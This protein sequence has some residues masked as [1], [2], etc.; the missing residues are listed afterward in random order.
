MNHTGHVHH[1][2][3]PHEHHHQMVT[4]TS[5]PAALHDSHH[6]H[7]SHDHAG[8]VMKMWFHGGC[9]EVILFDWWRTESCVGKIIKN[10]YL[11]KF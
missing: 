8:H 5:A 11:F 1:P 6:Q 4:T 3:D 9:N 10:K 7:A 2:H